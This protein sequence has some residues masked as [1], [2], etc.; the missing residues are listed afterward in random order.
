MSTPGAPPVWCF[1]SGS[2]L[3]LSVTVEGGSIRVYVVETDQNVKLGKV[4]D[5]V[6]WLN[7]HKA[8]SLQDPTVGLVDRLKQGKFLKW[9]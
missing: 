5:L 7:V 1:A 9:G 2:E 4:S 3:D 6:D 8:G